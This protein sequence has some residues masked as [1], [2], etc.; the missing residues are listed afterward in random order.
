MT[1]PIAGWNT[2]A[3]MKPMPCCSIAVSTAG[4]SASTVTPTSSSTSALPE[5]DDTE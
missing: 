2:G 1:A 5:L 3:S 4:G